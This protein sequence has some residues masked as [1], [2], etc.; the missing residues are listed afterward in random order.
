MIE[1]MRRKQRRIEQRE[2]AGACRAARSRRAQVRRG[3]VIVA[4]FGSV[5]MLSTKRTQIG[6]SADG[7]S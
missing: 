3:G 1:A 6:N 5:A 2:G 4:G 7:A